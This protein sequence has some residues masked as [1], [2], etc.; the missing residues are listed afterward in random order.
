MI[1]FV[2][3]VLRNMNILICNPYRSE[4]ESLRK[5]ID[6]E[7][8]GGRDT[9]NITSF[10]NPED[11]L[12]YLGVTPDHADV[13][14][15][16][17]DISEGDMTDY[18]ERIKIEHPGSKM[19]FVGKDAGNVERLFDIGLDYFLYSPLKRQNFR[20]CLQKLL[21]EKES[22]RNLILE[23]KSGTKRIP[24]KDILYLTSDRRIV[25]ICCAHQITESL[26]EKLDNMEGRLDDRF[27]RCHQSYLVN[28]DYISGISTEG[29]TLMDREF[30]PISQ[31]KYWATKKKYLDYI[32]ARG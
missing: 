18:A 26:Y 7:M 19:V 9:S 22:D 3:T 4:A 1:T 14:I 6:E 31:K 15:M 27:V 12:A 11:L 13:F 28:M 32:K 8:E 25:N 24:L 21:S 2:Q 29:F 17:R 20:H 23:N 10:P 30:V 5:W 16:S